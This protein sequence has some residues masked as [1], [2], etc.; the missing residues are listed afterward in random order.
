[1]VHAAFPDLRWE[2]EDVIVEGDKVVTRTSWGGTHTGA[3]M[4]IRA[5]GRHVSVTSMDFTR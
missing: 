2:I 3:S 5:T 4:G 1:M